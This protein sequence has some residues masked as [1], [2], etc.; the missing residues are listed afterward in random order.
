MTDKVIKGPRAGSRAETALSVLGKLGGDAVAL[1]RVKSMS[2]V[3]TKLYEFRS[4]IVPPLVKLGLITHDWPTDTVTL[5]TRGRA[6][7][8]VPDSAPQAAPATPAASEAGARQIAPSM[9]QYSPPVRMIPRPESLALL[10]MPSLQG[11]QR[12]ARRSALA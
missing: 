4:G 1:S 6:L 10:N 2:G 8:C 11:G 12:I 3:T 5:T 7:L 9:R